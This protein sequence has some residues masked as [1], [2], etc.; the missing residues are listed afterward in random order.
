MTMAIALSWRRFFPALAAVD[1]L[2]SIE[3]EPEPEAELGLA[4]DEP[5]PALLS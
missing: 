3:P 5:E 1:R 2:E 4:A